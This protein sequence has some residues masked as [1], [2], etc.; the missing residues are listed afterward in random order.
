MS[1][2]FNE[3]WESLSKHLDQALD[4]EE[5]ARAHWLAALAQRDPEM[6]AWVSD[7]LAA[8][9]SREFQQFLEGSAAAGA[10]EFSA[11][12]FI[13]R[14]VG[15]YLIDSEIG[16][17]G[18]GSVWRAH[19]ADGRY[20]GTVAIKFVHAAWLG[21]A[22]EQR[23]RIEGDIL[24]RLDHPNIAGSRELDDRGG[25][26]DHRGA[27]NTPLIDGGCSGSLMGG[28]ASTP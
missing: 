21:R 22:G 14:H 24:G 23:F 4:Q 17:G 13:G 20:E 16:R 12:T 11:A 19:R 26:T 1:G 9:G 7:A 2:V 28:V 8:R 27:A 10:A 15:P 18:M 5:P 25:G 3:R 6:A